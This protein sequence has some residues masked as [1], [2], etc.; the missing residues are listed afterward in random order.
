MLRCR[1]PGEVVSASEGVVEGGVVVPTLGSGAIPP[2][3]TRL[4]RE[5]TLLDGYHHGWLAAAGATNRKELGPVHV[6]LVAELTRIHGADAAYDGT[7]IGAL[8]EIAHRADTGIRRAGDDEG[9]V[10]WTRAAERRSP[11]AV[12]SAAELAAYSVLHGTP[13][14]P[15]A[16]TN[17]R[18]PW[19][20]LFLEWRVRLDGAASL[21]GWTLGSTDLGG[22]Q[23]AVTADS[24]VCRPLTSASRCRGCAVGRHPRV[25]GRGGPARPGRP[26]ELPARGRRRSGAG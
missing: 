2:E 25:A 22:A 3:V 9:R 11:A 13:P 8:T 26:V 6:R 10:N 18:Q 5:A 24:D 17:W 14:S 20:P 23:A 4:V 7:G 12:D 19:V 21:D 16:I 15:V 1:Y